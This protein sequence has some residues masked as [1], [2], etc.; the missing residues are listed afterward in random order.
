M[1]ITHHAA[2]DYDKMI[3]GDP[4]VEDIYAW[5]PD[6]QNVATRGR[7]GQGD[8]V[9]ILTG[10]IYVCGAEQGDVLQVSSVPV[11]G[12]WW[13]IFYGAGALCFAHSDSSFACNE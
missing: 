7:T 2:D 13:H 5:G 10:P 6:G 11:R 12:S 3:R 8:G 9:H 4:G 1:Q